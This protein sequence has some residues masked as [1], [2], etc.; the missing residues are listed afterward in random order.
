MT[1]RKAEPFELKEQLTLAGLRADEERLRRVVERVEGVHQGSLYLPF[2][3]RSDGL[4]MGQGHLFKVPEAVVSAFPQLQDA[5]PRDPAQ[6]DRPRRSRGRAPAQRQYRRANETASVSEGDP[7]PMD[8][9]I[10]ERGLQGHA[11]TQN[12]LA[13]HVEALGFDPESPARDDPQYDLLWRDGEVIH[14][15]EVKSLTESN[16]ER[17]LRLGLGQLLRYRHGLAEGDKSRAYLVCERKPS[18]PAWDELCSDLGVVLVWPAVL[19][20]RVQR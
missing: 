20:E 10:R 6:V 13:D 14:V 8:P 9:A 15:A 1:M 11:I 19:G 3:F 12:Q 16:E 18:D 5:A 2:Q 17:Q 4:R 7:F